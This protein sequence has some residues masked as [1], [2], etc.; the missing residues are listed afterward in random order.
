[1][2]HGTEMLTNMA[3][4]SLLVTMT[5]EPESLVALNSVSIEIH[6]PDLQIISL[7]ITLYL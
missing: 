6:A 7:P 3:A 5:E 4:T 1:M 2:G